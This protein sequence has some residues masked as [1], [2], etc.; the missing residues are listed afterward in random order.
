MAT[1]NSGTIIG[2]STDGYYV[3]IEW[4]ETYA[5]NISNITGKVYLVG[6]HYP[7]E[8]N[9]IKGRK[10]EFAVNGSIQTAS[11]E[12]NVVPST[13]PTVLMHTFTSNLG[14]MHNANGSA[15]ASIYASVTI[16]KPSYTGM[17]TIGTLSAS[18][19]VNLFTI[20]PATVPSAAASIE[21]GKTLSISLPRQSSAYAHDITYTFGSATGT[22]ATGAATSAL[23]TVPLNLAKQIKNKTSDS[24]EICC[25][26]KNGSTTIGTQTIYVMLKVPDNDTTKPTAN[27]TLTPTG[28]LSSTFAGLYIQGKTGVK[29]SF[30]ASSVYSTVSAYK[31]TVDNGLSA[32]GNPASTGAIN[33]SGTRTVKGTV[34]D[35]RGY[36]RVLSKTITVIPYASAAVKPADGESTVICRRCTADKTA[37]A[38]GTYLHIKA[39]RA[40]STVI[41]GGTQKNFCVLRYRHK[42][43][44]AADNAYSSWITLLAKNNTSQN[45]IDIAVAN[46]ISSVDNS[47]TIQINATDDIGTS[48]TLT[49]VIPTKMVAFSLKAGGNGAAFG[50]IAEE[51]DTVELASG[52]ALKINNTTLTEAQLIKLLKLI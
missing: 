1:G 43:S 47:Y 13:V 22:I 46:V 29:A 3:R 5:N 36:S 2:S 9:F 15:T 50:K 49:F 52:W 18:K 48:H 35:A 6:S 10:M 21:M 39:K 23:W 51:E 33:S 45:T 38:T 20:S 32:S 19:T 31:L 25:V 28:S 34:T 24:A 26:T 27:M 44:S 30:T 4:S 7:I 41:S 40:Y 12:Y 16:N 11:A 17:T 37:S 8:E 42:L 14:I